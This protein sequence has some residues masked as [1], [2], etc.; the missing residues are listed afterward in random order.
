MTPPSH[1][2]SES[3]TD[4]DRRTV[5]QGLN[6]NNC[7]FPN[8]CMLPEPHMELVEFNVLFPVFAYRYKIDIMT[9]SCFSHKK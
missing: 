4:E 7:Q 9:P 5:R 3:E 1:Y 8:S 2:V 6:N